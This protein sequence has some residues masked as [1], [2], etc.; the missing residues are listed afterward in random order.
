[1][2]TPVHVESVAKANR[3]AHTLAPVTAR[4]DVVSAYLALRVREWLVEAPGRT[5]A[6]L[7]KAAGVSKTQISN[8]LDGSRGAGRKTL[9]GVAAAIGTSWPVIE[10]EAAAWKPEHPIP[11]VVRET[12]RDDR[13]SSADLPELARVFVVT[14]TLCALRIGET[15]STPTILV[16]P[17][18]VRVR[19]EIGASPRMKASSARSLAEHRRAC[20]RSA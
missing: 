16:A 6:G 1:M 5:Q 8:L 7:A 13:Y 19:G 9:R 17:S 20:A 18:S 15:V 10:E 14:E 2:S 3:R 4:D 12:A 11:L